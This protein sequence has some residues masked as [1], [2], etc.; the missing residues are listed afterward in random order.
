MHRARTAGLVVC[1]LLAT[2][3]SQG[4]LAPRGANADRILTVF[5]ALL[6]GSVA[7]TLVVLALWAWG[8]LHRRDPELDEE[9]R[10]EDTP[11]TAVGR[12]LVIGGGLIMPAV[13]LTLFLGVQIATTTAQPQEGSGLVLEVIGHQYWWEITYR[14]MDG[15]DPFETANQAHVP[16]GTPVMLELRTDDVI[17]SFWVP[18]LAGKVDLVPGRLNQ[19]IMTAHEPGTYAGYCAEY[20]GLQHA[21]MKFEVVAMPPED[22][23]DWAE[24]QAAPATPPTGELA[25]EGRDVFLG[26]S[27]V[28]CHAIRGEAEQGD[29]GPDLTHLASRSRIGS[30]VLR[31][32][33]DN[34]RAWT[35]NP[36]A[37]K[38]GVR[39]PPQ[40][41]DEEELDALVTYLLDL[42]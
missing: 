27:C 30:G 4:G 3:C 15:V 34:L 14:G 23:Q 18:E 17:H 41:L 35:V 24:Q 25:A 26:N 7:V 32:D 29:A 31:L 16:T 9:A 28:G 20:C 13:V 37:I 2:A 10:A 38:P 42:E 22:F 33:E 39:M 40:H 19:L 1:V 21:W 11:D 6:L 8:A 36:Q 12:R 5:W